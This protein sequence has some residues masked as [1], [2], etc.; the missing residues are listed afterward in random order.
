MRPFLITLV[1]IGLIAAAPCSAQESTAFTYQGQLQHAG[2]PHTGEVAMTFSLWDS[3]TG[4]TQLGTLNEIIQVSDGLFQVE[5]DFGSQPWGSGLWLQISADGTDL[6]PR[7]RLTA[8]PL[9]LRSHFAAALDH[10]LGADEVDDSAIQLRIDDSCQFGWAIRGINTDGSVFCQMAGGSKW[11]GVA[12]DAIHHDGKV[13]VGITPEADFHVAGLEV[14]LPGMRLEHLEGGYFNVV[15]G[16]THNV[17]SDNALGATISGGGVSSSPN[18]VQGEFDTVGGGL[19]NT[20]GQPTHGVSTASTVAGGENNSSNGFHSSVGGGLGN[21]A[22][23]TAATVAGGIGNSSTG[24]R[25]TIGGGHNNL[26]QENNSTVGGGQQNVAGGGNAT[27]SGGSSNSATGIGASV[28][29]GENN[30]VSFNYS[31]IAGGLSNTASGGAAMIPGGLF[32]NAEGNYSLAAGRRAKANHNG[33]FVWADSADADFASTGPDQFVVRATGGVGF[34]EPP[35]DYF[36][37]NTPFDTQDTDYSFGTGALRVRIGGAT[38]FRVLG[39]GGVAVGSSYQSSGVPER[40]MRVSG[41][42]ELASLGTGGTTS[43]CRN[44]DGA[45]AECSSSARYKHDITSLEDAGALI[46][47]L[48]PVSYRWRDSDTEDFGLVAEEVAAIEPRLVTYNGDGQV[49]GVKYRQLSALLVRGFQEQRRDSDGLRAEV[50]ALRRQAD[51]THELT[52]RNAELADRV[53]R[54]E[55]LLLDRQR[56]AAEDQPP[57]HPGPIGGETGKTSSKP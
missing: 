32:N 10:P 52:R 55:A 12:G 42:V 40:G 13:G 5:L 44:G 8:A 29:G 41:L 3:Q 4:G 2:A 28:G 9:S 37:I 21:S 34:G 47:Q 43:L 11:A 49:E 25:S 23:G 14:I 16:S 1:L 51:R 38:R 45:I 24:T 33:A 54:L 20:A 57:P 15:G 53:D 18:S 36:V 46:E 6:P 22:N 50:S 48:R 26:A 19:G 30:E 7:Q 56:M 31:T 17:L 35:S 39:N 27:I